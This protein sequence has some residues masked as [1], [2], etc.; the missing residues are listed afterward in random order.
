MTW[1]SSLSQRLYVKLPGTPET[2]IDG[3]DVA[4]VTKVGEGI[5]IVTLEC[6][7]EHETEV[8][9]PSLTAENYLGH[10]LY[11]VSSGK[12]RR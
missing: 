6:G 1:E 3:Q 7:A 5:F 4:S 8:E 10:I 12:G 11:S 2:W 9:D